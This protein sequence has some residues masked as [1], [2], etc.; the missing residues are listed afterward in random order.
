M[1]ETGEVRGYMNLAQRL[2]ET[3]SRSK[4][5]LLDEAADT[6]EYLACMLVAAECE[7]QQ[8]HRDILQFKATEE[9]PTPLYSRLNG[10]AI[11][12]VIRNRISG[13]ICTQIYEQ[14]AYENV[15]SEDS[16]RGTTSVCCS[17][18]VVMPEKKCDD[19]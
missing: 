6:I 9:F 18:E 14:G 5:K 8:P 15:F 2:R 11:D 10:S 13:G 7:N 19:N 4:R 1:T 16:V 3:E 12:S 17:V